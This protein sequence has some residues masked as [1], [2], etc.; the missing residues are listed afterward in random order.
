MESSASLPGIARHQLL[1]PRV[2]VVVEAHA[3]SGKIG[4]DTVGFVVE[5]ADREMAAIAPDHE[6]MQRAA[7]RSGG[8][9]R[10]AG[11]VGAD[12]LSA[13]AGALAG[14][15]VR[16]EN[17]VPLHSDLWLPVLLVSALCVEWWV[18]RTR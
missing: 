9:F 12:F 4:E 17:R 1:P 5:E 14:E 18:R 16:V 6:S 8:M 15:A 11:A 3:A 13:L 2:D 7:E 10:P